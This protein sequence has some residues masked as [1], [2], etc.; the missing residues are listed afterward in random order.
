MRRAIRTG[1]STTA[2]LIHVKVHF[3]E[4]T[5]TT[6]RDDLLFANAVAGTKRKRLRSL[7][8]LADIRGIRPALRYKIVGIYEVCIVAG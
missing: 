6:C 2:R 3:F 5:D 1:N 7:L 8:Y 4:E